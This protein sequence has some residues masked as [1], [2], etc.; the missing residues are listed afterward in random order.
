MKPETYY[1]V[2]HGIGVKAT[3]DKKNK[4]ATTAAFLSP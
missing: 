4:V 1:V 3:A 2:Y